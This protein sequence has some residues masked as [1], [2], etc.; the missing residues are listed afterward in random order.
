MD[1]V[2]ATDEEIVPSSGFTAAAMERVRQA[3]ATPAPIPFPWRRAI[4]GI[5]LA[6]GVF[7][8]GAWETVRYMLPEARQ[9]LLI[10][11]ELSANT[12]HGLQAAGWVALALAVSLCSWVFSVRLVRRSG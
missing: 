7:G 2:L 11:P 1:R 8:W 5:V 3:A 12:A 9:V 6:A 4:P 10:P